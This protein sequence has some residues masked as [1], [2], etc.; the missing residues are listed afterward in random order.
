M[1]VE[2][3]DLDLL[4]NEL[5]VNLSDIRERRARQLQAELDDIRARQKAAQAAKKKAYEDGLINYFRSH[6][7]ENFLLSVNGNRLKAV[8]DNLLMCSECGSSIASL[9]TSIMEAV[10]FYQGL[11]KY[12]YARP[13]LPVFRT[14][15][16]C[17]CGKHYEYVIQILL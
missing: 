12:G 6:Y 8:D 9:H 11:L 4:A 15:Q 13:E 14:S 17:T 1:L 2:D 7:T 16:H 10:V 3:T 5:G